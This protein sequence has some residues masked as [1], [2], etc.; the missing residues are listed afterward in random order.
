MTLLTQTWSEVALKSLSDA[1]MYCYVP[2]SRSEK[3]KTSM[4]SF[5]NL[6]GA[7]VLRFRS[8][9]I[10]YD[11]IKIERH[12]PV[13][14]YLVRVYLKKLQMRS[15]S[16]KKTRPITMFYDHRATSVVVFALLFSAFFAIHK[17][18]FFWH[19]NKNRSSSPYENSRTGLAFRDRTI[20]TFCIRLAQFYKERSF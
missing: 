9:K 1:M 16:V 15:L 6:P 17:M 20:E 12:R 5:H 4:V 13:K 10:V 8:Y 11:R 14:R 19:F 2:S 7:R 3:G 18:T